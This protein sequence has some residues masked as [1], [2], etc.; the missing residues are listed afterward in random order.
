MHYSVYFRLQEVL[1]REKFQTV[2]G[3]E[4]NFSAVWSA[5]KNR[6]PF[7]LVILMSH[8]GQ[9]HVFSRWWRGHENSRNWCRLK[10]PS[11]PTKTWIWLK[12]MELKQVRDFLTFSLVAN[13]VMCH[14]V[15]ISHIHVAYA[16]SMIWNGDPLKTDIIKI[17][18]KKKTKKK[19][20]IAD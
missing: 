5:T 17:K 11:H 4:G 16:P 20:K 15:W 2:K 3:S 1:S 9:C 14:D 10:Y 6:R 19:Q 13:G 12:T 7:Q 8:G 18:I